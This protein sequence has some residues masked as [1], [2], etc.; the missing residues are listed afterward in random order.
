MG[1]YINR[2]RPGRLCDKGNKCVCFFVRVRVNLFSGKI[3]PIRL[4]SV[5]GVQHAIRGPQTKNQNKAY[6]RLKKLVWVTKNESFIEGYYKFKDFRLIFQYGLV[7][8][9]NPRQTEAI[10]AGLNRRFGRRAKKKPA[11][12]VKEGRLK[13]CYD[14]E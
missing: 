6:F 10:R 12:A 13:V 5:C 1:F 2:F 7:E 4:Y 3:S 11:F 9:W 14:H 8:L